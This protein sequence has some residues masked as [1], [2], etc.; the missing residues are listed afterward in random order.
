MSQPDI[1][2]MMSDQHAAWFMGHESGVTDTPNMDLLAAEGTRFINHYTACPLCVP[3]RMSMLSGCFPTRIGVTGNNHT[4][5]DTA[6][7][8]LYALAAAGYETVLIGR[9]HFAGKDLRHGFTRRLGGDMTPTSWVPPIKEIAEERGKFMPTF[10][11]R[12]CLEVIGG[13]ESPVRYFDDDTI[14][15]AV[16]YLSKPHEKPQ[17][18]L[19]GTFGPHFPYV[20]EPEL[21]QKY[22]E[23]G[24][25]PSTFD[26]TPDF[27]K[28]NHWLVSHQ[29]EV[30]RETGKK[31]AAAYC[32]MIEETDRHLGEL[33]RAFDVYT[34]KYGHEAVFGYMSDHG[35]TV[36]ARNM[37]GKQTFFEDSVRVPFILSGKGIPKGKVIRENTSLLDIGPTICSMAGTSYEESWIDGMDLTPLISGQLSDELADRPVVSQYIESRGGASVWEPNK[38]SEPEQVSYGIMIRWNKW[39]YFVYHGL[40]EQAVLLDMESDPEELRN[41]RKEYPAITEKLHTIAMQIISPEQAEEAHRSHN[42]MN[43]WLRKYEQITG[44]RLDERW[45][46]NPPTAKG[47]LIIQ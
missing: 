40:E 13:G 15:E 9:M 12:G 14:R 38:P 34:Q 22:L 46:N 23:R 41:V 26:S 3:A 19:V 20:A 25:L 31:A 5:A 24:W 21:Y 18:I 36:G 32:A 27:V 42:Q 39:K 16:E 47:K 33:R 4:L 17:F 11:T 28:E 7:T 35:D 6:P 1:L 37:Y 43:K 45:K 8:F 10:S 44:E 30:D 2:L 29:K